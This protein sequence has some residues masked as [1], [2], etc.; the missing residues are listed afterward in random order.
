MLPGSEKWTQVVSRES[1]PLSLSLDIANLQ[2]GLHAWYMVD[3]RRIYRY[4]YTVVHF[5]LPA[6]AT[7]ISGRPGTHASHSGCHCGGLQQ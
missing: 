7:A 4:L 5:G 2:R 3:K 1:G 6:G